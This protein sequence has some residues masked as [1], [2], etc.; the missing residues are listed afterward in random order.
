M[1]LAKQTCQL[2][3]LNLSGR[4]SVRVRTPLTLEAVT[5]FALACAT[6]FKLD[7]ALIALHRLS[8]DR[9]WLN[10]RLAKMVAIVCFNDLISP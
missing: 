1:G 9:A 4:L 3:A 6:S 8:E 5:V 2:N 10:S 7:I